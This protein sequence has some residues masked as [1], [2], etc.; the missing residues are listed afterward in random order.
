MKHISDR[1]PQCVLLASVCVLFACVSAAQTVVRSFDG[2]SGPGLAECQAGKTWCGRQSETNVA[3][4]GRQ[5]VQVTWQNVRIYDY[6]GKLLQS[7]PMATFVRNA[8]M[9]PMPGRKGEGKGPFEPHVLYDEFVGR[10]L[11]SVTAHSDSLLVSASG[12]ATGKWGGVYPGCLDGGPCLDND[13]GTKLGYDRNGVYY[14]GAHLNEDNPET[15]PDTA[16]DCF[17]FPAAEVKSIAQGVAPI[18]INRA[19]RMPIDVVPAI[20]NNPNKAP[21]APAFFLA[22]SCERIKP[23][24]CGVSAGNFPFQWLVNTF[25]WNGLTGTYNKNG[26]EQVLKTEEEFRQAKLKN[27]TR[28]LE[29]LV[30]DEYYGVNQWGAKRDKA[31]LIELFSSFQT[32]VLVPTDVTVR[33][34]GDHAIVDGTMT[35]SSGGGSRFTYLF[36]RVFVRRGDAWKLLSSVQF[37]PGTP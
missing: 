37:I 1:M 3:A 12:D 30:A 35:E 4:N 27:D 2:D 14:C 7:I 5:V 21:D 34:A 25:T 17:A 26:T 19:H 9:D 8:G 28:A 23:N 22:K 32:E 6:N 15:A 36:L 11:I 33:L 24:S 16:W 13:P 10:W 18:H 31:Q 20:D 29:R